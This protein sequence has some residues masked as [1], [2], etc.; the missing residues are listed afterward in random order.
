MNQTTESKK[1]EIDNAVRIFREM[2]EKTYL[3]KDCKEEFHG[4]GLFP[5]TQC[6]SGEFMRTSKDKLK[7]PCVFK[8]SDVIKDDVKGIPM[9][10]S[11]WK[12]FPMIFLLHHTDEFSE[13][14]KEKSLEGF[15]K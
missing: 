2:L 5:M 8:G 10:F 11:D 15:V 6:I 1:R 14:P 3:V 9:R 4:I 7:V 12:L 13:K